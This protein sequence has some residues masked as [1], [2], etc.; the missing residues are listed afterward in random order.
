MSQLRASKRQENKR[1]Q[2]IGCVISVAVALGLGF[3]FV[4]L[5]GLLNVGDLL[6]LLLL[7]IFAVAGTAGF[8]VNRFAQKRLTARWDGI[9]EGSLSEPSVRISNTRLRLGDSFE[10]IYDQ[11]TLQAVKINGITV[12]LVQRTHE[13]RSFVGLGLGAYDPYPRHWD[14]TPQRVRRPGGEYYQGH[15]LHEEVTLTIPSRNAPTFVERALGRHVDW[16]V[17]VRL[18]IS[19]GPDFIRD[20][21]LQVAPDGT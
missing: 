3:L 12:E 9:L 10:V 11:R 8:F 21:P 17:R 20:Y 4:Y 1:A 18:R 7:P 6:L 13:P 15:G 5:M 16:L 2:S 14:R 19:Q